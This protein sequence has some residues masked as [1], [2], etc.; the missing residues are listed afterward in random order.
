M[1]VSTL[2]E[3]GRAIL[4]EGVRY[5]V[6]AMVPDYGMLG[7][8]VGYAKVGK[9]TLGVALVRAVSGSAGEFLGRAVSKRR[10]LYLALEDP[11]EYLAWMMARSLAGTED[12]LAYPGSLVLDEPT[13]AGLET[14]VRREGVGL[15]YVSTFTAGVRGLVRDE[16]DNAQLTGVVESLKGFTRRAG[17]PAL[18]EAH[19]GKGEDQSP[20]ADPVRALRGASAAAAAADFVLSLKR[21]GRGLTTR[22]V[23][24]GGGR[25]VNFPPLAF[26]YD[27]QT[28]HV[29]CLGSQKSAGAETTWR[30][31]QEVGALSA[32][33]RSA[34]AIAKAAGM[35][36]NSGSR[37][38]VRA[39]LDDRHGVE[40]ITKYQGTKTVVYFRLSDEAVTDPGATK[41]PPLGFVGAKR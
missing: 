9:S 11:R 25:F 27:A 12:A 18:L 40:R 38:M 7:F 36:D 30:L 24:S 34:S 8:L 20:D 14:F 4:A 22:R 28:G 41:C 10:V 37:A 15:I 13:L 33:E 35:T 21:D 26:D 2:V 1:P 31:I 17:V 23:L 6:D 32:E 16:N 5:V 29:E 19:S 3:E 39:A